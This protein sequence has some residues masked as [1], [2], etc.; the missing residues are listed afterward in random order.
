MLFDDNEEEYEGYYDLD[1]LFNT[2]TGM[3]PL[4]QAT[5][6]RAFSGM[7]LALGVDPGEL[8]GLEIVVRDGTDGRQKILGNREFWYLY[9]QRYRAVDVRDS[10]MTGQ[11]IEKYRKLGVRTQEVVPDE[12]K[13]SRRKEATRRSWTRMKTELK[14]NISKNLP[15]NV[16][17]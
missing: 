11:L 10:V 12:V 9:R 16:P 8:S 14:H 2:E 7:E 15:R 3:A 6:S 13:R 5:R 17:Y 4:I 1:A